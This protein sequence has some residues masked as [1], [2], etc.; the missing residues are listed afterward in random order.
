MICHNISLYDVSNLILFLS[1]GK[2]I[3]IKISNVVYVLCEQCQLVVK[4]SLIIYITCI[5]FA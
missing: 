5:L 1:Y 4:V 3:Y 2:T